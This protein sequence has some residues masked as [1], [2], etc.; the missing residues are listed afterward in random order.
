MC[1]VCGV[2]FGLCFC[3]LACSI[4]FWIAL[5]FVCGFVYCLLFVF[6]VWFK[7]I[8]HCVFIVGCACGCCCCCCRRRVLLLLSSHVVVVIV[9]AC[10]QLLSSLLL[11]VDDV[12]TGAVVVVV[13]VVVITFIVVTVVIAD[14]YHC[15]D[16]CYCCDS[17]YCDSLSCNNKNNANANKQILA[18]T[19]IIIV[20]TT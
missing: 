16:S 6:D 5:D 15:R 14:N 9:F 11:A 12:V 20:P 7:H 19:R 13:T 17:C 1:V 18:M 4:C 10:R 2:T 3:L 8:F